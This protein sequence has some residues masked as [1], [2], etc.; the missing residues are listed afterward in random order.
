M[1]SPADAPVNSREDRRF[2]QADDLERTVEQAD[3]LLEAAQADKR[4]VIPT[5]AIFSSPL[6]RFALL[7]S[8]KWVI[9]LA[10]SP[11]LT[12]VSFLWVTWTGPKSDGTSGGH[13]LCSSICRN[14]RRAA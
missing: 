13:A 9:R 6:V 14:G 3:K 2:P 10:S 7:K 4:R 1:V 11:G 12:G 5:G 8:M